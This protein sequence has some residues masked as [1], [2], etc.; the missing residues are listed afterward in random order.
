[1]SFNYIDTLERRGL[2]E[3]I[4]KY[5]PNNPIY[6]G[7]DPTYHSLHLGHLYLLYLLETLRLQGHKIYIIIGT[8]TVMI[9]DPSELTLGRAE[10][11]NSKLRNN[12]VN[13][14]RQIKTYFPQFI[15]LFNTL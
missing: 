3:V 12:I 8:F 9:G 2:V 5:S 1:M 7:I 10:F 13:L 4:G 15:I 14:L 6:M 11:D